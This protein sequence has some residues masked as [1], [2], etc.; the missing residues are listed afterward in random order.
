MQYQ[1]PKIFPDGKAENV[2][3][4]FSGP[5]SPKPFTALATNL[6]PDLNFLSP[7]ADGCRIMPFY[8]YTEDG[9]RVD[10]ITDWA[11]KQFQAHYNDET[12]TRLNAFHYVYAVLHHSAYREEYKLNLRRGFPRI[13]FYDDFWQWV[14]WG[15]TLMDLHLNYET[16]TR[17]PLQRIDKSVNPNKPPVTP[18]AKLKANKTTGTIE[19]DTITTFKGLP[20]SAWDYKLGTRSALEWVLEC[21]KEREPS[22]PTIRQEFNAYRFADYKAQVIDLLQRVCTVSVE[23]MKIVD[24]MNQR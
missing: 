2:V 18:K 19:L 22:D 17:Y 11:L 20:A 15:Q 7:A 21:H 16:T 8:R 6:V 5:N 9:N 10:N 4:A 12:I 14:D 3:I 1:L 23:T 24:E 13:P